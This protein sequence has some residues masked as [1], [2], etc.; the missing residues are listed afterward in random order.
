MEIYLNL[1]SRNYLFEDYKQSK[2]ILDLNEMES[3]LNKLF[4]MRKLKWFIVLNIII[5]KY[6]I[7]VLNWSCL[8]NNFVNESLF[9]S[10]L[11]NRSLNKQNR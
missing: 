3:A 6:P 7:L 2:R 11:S 9:N 1:P 10:K 5:I 4:T 8:F